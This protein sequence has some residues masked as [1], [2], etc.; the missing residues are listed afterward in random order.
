M[1]VLFVHSQMPGGGIERVTLTLL[2]EFQKRGVR[3]SLAL[4]C[5]QGEFI[6]EACALTD[7]VE[8]APDGM[9]S[10]IPQLADLIKRFGPTHIV[11]AMPDVTLLTLVARRWA[12]SAACT[13]QGVHLTQKRVAYKKTVSGAIRW[14]Y[15]RLLARIAYQRVDSVVAVSAGIRDELRE[16]FGISAGRI[17]LIH[18]PVV[19]DSDIASGVQARTSAA[20]RVRLCSVGRLSYQKGLDVLIRALRQVDGQWEL[21][22]HG[23]GAER[24]R[25]SELVNSCGLAERVHL[26]GHTDDPLHAIDAA[27]WFVMPSRFEGFGV[28]LVEALARGVPAIASDCPHGPRE[29]LNDGEFGVL[30]CPDDVDALSTALQRAIDGHYHFDSGKLA[31]RASN[32]SV[33][34]SAARWLEMLQGARN[35]SDSG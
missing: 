1:R 26:R 18:N 16:Q 9:R 6:D 22:I 24:D 34:R 20:G 13:I 32:Y 11:T 31:R 25:L 19:R 12:R 30:V 14:R 7:V 15:E 8:L 27:D 2:E 23:N 21:E 4:R 29:I 33:S 10:F 17:R 5:A 3:C 35:D 28:V